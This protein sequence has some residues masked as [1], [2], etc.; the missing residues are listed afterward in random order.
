MQRV[1]LINA[2]QQMI[3]QGRADKWEP[4]SIGRTA[5]F[6]AALVELAPQTARTLALAYPYLRPAG[7]ASNAT[8]ANG[9]SLT[10]QTSRGP[11]QAVLVGPRSDFNVQAGS[12][13]TYTLRTV[14]TY[15]AAEAT[16]PGDSGAAIWDDRG[17]LIGIHCGGIDNDP[18]GLSNA[19]FCAIDPVLEAFGVSVMVDAG[20]NMPRWAPNAPL[21]VS[22]PPSAAQDQELELVAK[23]IWGEAG[24]L[25]EA[26]MNAVAA[27]IR[28]RK[29]YGKWMGKSYLEV[30]L[31]P[32]QFRC[33]DESSPN[34]HRMRRPAPE[35]STLNQARE[36]AR[37]AMGS[38]IVP[39]PTNGATRYHPDGIAPLWAK[40]RQASADRIAGLNFYRAD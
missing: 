33:W 11:I 21:P 10:V 1:D 13:G 22:T 28:N 24:E 30:C 6:D 7:V 9:A 38:G 8:L 18:A 34:I 23:T 2:N 31:R 5:G 25:G 36:I 15:R 32:F 35:D 19:F 37:R 4:A 20:A 12:G 39:D 40:G 29:D 26:A 27:V 14:M 16:R 17:H 3:S